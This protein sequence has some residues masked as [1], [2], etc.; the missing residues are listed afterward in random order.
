MN[1]PETPPIQ[2]SSAPEI[3]ASS[4]LVAELPEA[5]AT[6][7]AAPEPLT[8][9]D[10]PAAEIPA[11]PSALIRDRS[12]VRLFLSIGAGF[13]GLFLFVRTAIVEPFGVPTGSMAPSLI[14]NHRECD[15]SRCGFHVKVGF[16]SPGGS[17][18]EQFRNISCPNCGQTLSL[19]DEQNLGG[20]RLLV[21]KN[22]FNIRKPRRWEMAVF[23]CPDTD[24]HELGKPYVKRVIGLPGETIRITEGDVYAND[25]LL[26]KDLDEVRET[27][28]VVLDMAHSPRPSGWN[29]RW[30]MEPPENDPRLPTATGREL[31]VADGS[32]VNGGVI[33][34]DATTN[35]S[36]S[37]GVR[38]RH[39]NLDEQKE[40]PVRAWCSYDGPIRSMGQLPV[41]HDFSL[42][43][44]IE[45]S[46]ANADALFACSLSDG[47]DTVVAE[48][49][50]GA[51]AWPVAVVHQG[52]GELSSTA[53]VFL[54]PGKTVHLE[55]AFV[56]RR[57]S[58]AIDGRHATPAADL[59]QG[60]KRGPVRC[61]L[62]LRA[63]GCRL[64][65]RDLV[66]YRDIHYTQYGEH[67]T[68]HAAVLGPNEYFMLGDNS[69][70][71][72]DSRKWPSPGVPEN[73]FIGKPFL[74]HQ[75]L[76]PAR[77]TVGGRERVFQTLD[78]S[79]LRWLH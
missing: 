5:A 15:C 68:R 13:V 59:P 41:V 76:R 17:V 33:T 78:W 72:Q 12:P 19:V 7:E 11:P 43:C 31:E 48:I 47:A 34:L 38:Y 79:R 40:E 71:S 67:G 69:G 36:P 29:V 21:D 25:V 26:R 6:P 22:V 57:V 32:V 45:V 23:R 24:P 54:A 28:L 51:S 64:L 10:E 56:D 74:I 61:P 8:L 49:P 66:L 1:R 63:R 58:L 60:K 2:D 4:A 27:R 70:N 53:G 9:S 75:P 46:A 42:A 3:P 50:V 30:L 18:T 52:Q 65:I 37:A 62:Q 73:D 39:W 16:P 77:V 14:G 55:F 20:D 44:D 35:E